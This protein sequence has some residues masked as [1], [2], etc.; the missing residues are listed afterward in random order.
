MAASPSNELQPCASSSRNQRCKCE[1]ERSNRRKSGELLRTC[2]RNRWSA[3]P[4]PVVVATTEA[5][6]GASPTIMRRRRNGRNGAR[7]SLLRAALLSGSARRTSPTCPSAR[8]KPRRTLRRPKS[9]A[10]APRNEILP[11]AFEAF[12][13]S[14]NPGCRGWPKSNRK[15]P[16]LTSDISSSSTRRP[17]PSTPKRESSAMRIGATFHRLRSRLLVASPFRALTTSSGAVWKFTGSRTANGARR[18]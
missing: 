7:H 16:A 6:T 17:W 14:A 12:A 9:R 10:R 8:P 1:D 15:G 13:K 11:A 2:R 4:G 5:A 3:P 18:R